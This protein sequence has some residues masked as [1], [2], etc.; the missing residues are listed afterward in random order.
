M[1]NHHLNDDNGNKNEMEYAFFQFKWKKFR[2]FVHFRSYGDGGV[3][4]HGSRGGVCVSRPQ[5]YH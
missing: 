2:V 3:G 4:D 1:V 5:F